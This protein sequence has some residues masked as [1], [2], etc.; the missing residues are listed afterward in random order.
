MAISDKNSDFLLQFHIIIVILQPKIKIRFINQRLIE[1]FKK[2]LIGIALVA[3]AG[4]Y[5]G[6]NRAR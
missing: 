6:T 4:H 1:M 2:I 3:L 5:D